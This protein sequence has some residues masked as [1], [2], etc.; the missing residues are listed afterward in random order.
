MPRPQHYCSERVHA[1][2]LLAL[3]RKAGLLNEAIEIYSACV[4]ADESSPINW[5]RARDEIQDMLHARGIAELDDEEF[6]ISAA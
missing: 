4:P 2:S 3:A 6:Q 5:S 1:V